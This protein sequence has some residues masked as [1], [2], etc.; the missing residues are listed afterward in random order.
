M[1]KNL[2]SNIL[3]KLYQREKM[4]RI[5]LVEEFQIRPATLYDAVNSLKKKGILLEPDRKSKK[6]GRK[7]PEIS[8]NERHGY[9]GG[10]EIRDDE[11][12]FVTLN[13]CGNLEGA[14]Q[15]PL[16]SHPKV[17]DVHEALTQLLKNQLQK[18]DRIGIPYRAI[19]VADLGLV[20]NQKGISLK[21]INIQG[22]ELIP[23]CH[24]IQKI[25]QVPVQLYSANNAR[26]Y[27]E[28]RALPYPRPYS[29]LHIELDH[30]IGSGLIQNGEIYNGFNGCALEIGHLIVEENGPHCLCGNRGC[31]ESVIGKISLEKRI[32]GLKQEN[33]NTVLNLESFDYSAF[34][35]ALQT[36]DKAAFGIFMEIVKFLGIGISSTVTLLNPE[37]IILSG[38]L[39]NTG[40]KLLTLLRQ[41]LSMRCLP[42]ALKNL[43]ILIS[44]F[45]HTATAEGA[46]A[47]ALRENLLNYK[48]I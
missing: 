28:Y 43:E 15:L 36:S 46:A 20:D 41:Q 18:S 21:A 26:A 35:K 10:I 40:E 5:E 27:R 2:H 9:Y 8:I 3:N 4:T 39:T 38:R 31:L 23:I 24:W 42:H 17:E 48:N 32:N 19:A 13:A 33:V 45:D 25:V 14:E 16:S 12:I 22:W 37:K 1:I 7:A 11:I 44:S 30:G 34:S 29:L 6:T 47:L